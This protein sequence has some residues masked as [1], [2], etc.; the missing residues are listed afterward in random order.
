[1][2]RYLIAAALI[3]ILAAGLILAVSGL[4]LFAQPSRW[5][6]HVFGS[7]GIFPP[8]GGVVLSW[9]GPVLTILVAF[10]VA[11][12]AVDIP[13]PGQKMLVFLT[14]LVFLAGFSLSLA[15][16]GVM[17]E[18]F[19]PICAA[20]LAAGAGLFYSGTEP[21]RR[22][23]VL[24]T[25]LGSRV[26][27]T[28]FRQLLDRRESVELRGVSREA[29]VLTCRIFN[30]AGQKE[31][32][33]PADLVAMTNLFLR[34]TADFLMERGAYV[35]DS[36][37]DCVRVFFGLLEEDPHHAEVACRAALELGQRLRNLD[38]ECE[39]RWFRRLRHGIALCSGHVTAGIYG[40]PKH[41]CLSAV[42]PEIDLCRRLSR[43]NL[44]YQSQIILG[45]STQAR[46]ADRIE[47]RPLEM[48]YDPEPH[49]MAEIYELLG[50]A[51]DLNPLQAARRDAFWEGVIHY[52]AARYEDAIERFQAASTPGVADPP[53]AYF[54]DQAQT[55]L[56]RV[57]RGRLPD[58][59]DLVTRG[60]ARLLGSL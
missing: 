4:G 56:G 14:T 24:Q 3:G 60:H 26:S 12:C 46:L 55:R 20:T 43:A 5:L 34:N 25:A 11:W 31:T 30:H 8:A 17:A 45:A 21:G 32:L 58:D 13:E 41:F 38:A 1:M 48:F 47:I 36:S 50:M 49:A 35:D 6:A 42:G 37:P 54:V 57:A 44:L 29:T 15:L 16:F 22:K 51:G 59:N 53:V 19:A 7:A 23:R 27:K 39:S 52:R 10:G 9:L 28:L 33:P 2:R 18:P 40:S